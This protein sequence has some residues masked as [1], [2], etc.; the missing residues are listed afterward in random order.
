MESE[1]VKILG[2]DDNNDNLIVLKALLAD[3]LPNAKFFFAD[4]GK[5]GIAL[6]KVEL[7]D[8]ILL[9]IIMPVMDGFEVCTKLKEDE[10]LKHIPIIF[11]TAA[12][13]DIKS[14]IKALEIGADAF[15]TKPIDEAELAAQVKAML[16]IKKSEEI[17]RE[18]KKTLSELV[19]DRTAKLE[20]EL[21]EHKKTE[22]SLRIAISE[23]EESKEA[24]FSLLQELKNEV[25]E[26]KTIG[27]ALKKS[28]SRYKKAQAIGHVGNWEYNHVTSYFWASDE[29]KRI[30]GFENDSNEFSA[31]LVEN[32]IPE[33]ERVHQALI[34][35]I[36]NNKIYDL[37]F[38]ILTKNNG[39][40]KTIHSIAEVEKDNEG[41]IVKVTGVLSDITERKKIEQEL[42]KSNELFRIAFNQQF[43]FIS[44]LSPEGHIVEINELPL[45]IQGGKREELIGKYFWELP[46]WKNN[47]EW[48]KKIKEQVRKV[49]KTEEPL[50]TEDKFSS[51][52]GN[53]RTALATYTPIRNADN[54]VQYILA[55]ATDITKSKLTELAIKKSELEFRTVWENSASGMRI[56]NEKG[57]IVKVN[58]AY[59]E[60][61]GKTKEELEGNILSIV[62][63][64]KVSEHIQKQ[65]QKRFRTRTIKTNFEQELSIWNNK[66]IWIH[67]S[68]SFLDIP[69]EE[70]LILGVFTDISKRKKAEDKVKTLNMAIEQNPAI[71]IIT[72]PTGTIEYVNPKFC[73]ITG[74][75]FDEAIGNN[76]KM[77]KSGEKQN[78]EYKELWNTITSGSTWLGEFQ[79]K[80]KDGS[81]YWESASISPIY[82]EKN[83]IAHFVAVKE[84]I[85]VKREQEKHLRKSEYILNETQSLSKVGGW[86]YKIAEKRM[87]WT[88]EVFKIHGLPIG[89]VP[90]IEETYK[91]YH[92]EYSKLI[93]ESFEKCI[94]DGIPYKMEAEFINAN[95]DELWVETSGRPMELD[96]KVYKVVGNIVDI[97]KR[98]ISEKELKKSKEFAE[99]ADK[100]KSIFLAQMSHE[101]RTPINAIVSMTSLMKMDFEET[102]DEDLLQ[103]FEIIDRAGDRIIRT[104]DLLLNL[105]EVQAGTYESNPTLVDIHTDIIIPIIAENKKLSKKKNIE[106]SIRIAANDTTLM[107]DLFTVSQIF[108]QLIDNAIKYTENGVVTVNIQLNS[109]QKLVVEI[110]DTGVG[111]ENDY[112]VELF[113]PF[114]QEEMGYTRKYDGNGIGLALVKTYCELNNAEIEVES[115]KGVGSTFRVM[116]N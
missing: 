26:R 22:E 70:P 13:T 116:F 93:K 104:V 91:Y 108:T 58:K 47:L 101:I 109:E 100:M 9:D 56:T 65:H 106:F 17:L 74:Y 39:I 115:L 87:I 90:A 23:L 107:I 102:A 11:L 24:T 63:S 40:R 6:A 1:N 37:V 32:C 77:L 18:E 42:F 50:L 28:E 10:L 49:A 79:N 114:S 59:C 57:I 60:L 94:I 41:N 67:V 20:E 33:R 44:V 68:N 98:K 80:K 43:Q 75:T 4:S 96:G 7:P 51:V 30:Y 88:N 76:P 113:E 35:L 27:V 86:E 25:E 72:D 31:D 111:I 45:K 34:D 103:S 66:K 112:L 81:L 36:E 48:Q 84:D 89:K 97:T 3:K 15:V 46:A 83:E 16:R 8:V 14:R 71:I 61:F 21:D 53:I 92:K 55:Q 19:K 54:N 82:D 95:G 2:I 78:K 29:A 85:T 5:K 99:N 105:S 62:Y 38:D 69:S 12:K 52:D 110:E 73:E 64:A